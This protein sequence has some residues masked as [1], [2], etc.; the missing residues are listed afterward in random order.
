MGNWW[1]IDEI[2]AVFRID[3]IKAVF[4]RIILDQSENTDL[5]ENS[6]QFWKGKDRYY[7]VGISKWA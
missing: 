4:R 3:E 7:G 2:K 6:Y 1:I 5:R